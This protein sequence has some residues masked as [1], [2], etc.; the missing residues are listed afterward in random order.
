MIV[1][2]GS[3]NCSNNIC[4]KS[5]YSLSPEDQDDCTAGYRIKFR[6]YF[7]KGSTNGNVLVARANAGTGLEGA[8]NDKRLNLSMI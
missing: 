8:L 2:D 3:Q 7:K 5:T 6:R 1:K 4:T